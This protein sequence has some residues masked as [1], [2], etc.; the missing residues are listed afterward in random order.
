M[1]AGVSN[2]AQRETSL[3][4]LVCSPDKFINKGEQHAERGARTGKTAVVTWCAR[5]LGFG[6]KSL[7]YECMMSV[8]GGGGDALGSLF[9]VRCA[10]CAVCMA[11]CV[12]QTPHAGVAPRVLVCAHVSDMRW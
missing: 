7:R 6:V 10:L 2:V 8:C 9:V 1:K 5:G 3:L 12:Q 4:V 11:V